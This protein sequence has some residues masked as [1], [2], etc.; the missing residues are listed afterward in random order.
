M[1]FVLGRDGTDGPAA[2]LGV[3]RAIDGSDGAP[4]AL[5]LERP[6][7][8]TVVGK[9]GYGKSH[10]LGVLAEELAATPGLAPVVVDPMG[11]FEPL[12]VQDAVDATVTT[13]PTVDPAALD[14][15]SWCPLVGLDPESGPGGLVWDA[16]RAADS[17]AE[18][19]DHVGLA[20]APAADVRAA[21]NHLAMAEAWGVFDPDGLG[22]ADLAGDEVTVLDCSGL[23]SGPMNAL[24]RVV[25]ETCYRARVDERID[26]LPW[27]LVDEAHAFFD[28]IAA[29]A[30]ETLLTRGRAPG[31]SL[32][33]ATQRPSAVPDVCLSQTDVLLAH[34]LTSEADIA[35][36]ESARPT[37]VDRSFAARMPTEVGGAVVVDD[38][39]ETAH[40]VRIRDRRT[41]HGGSSPRA[42]EAAPTD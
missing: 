21:R 42:S 39:T 40:A 28:G 11:A 1:T 32:V 5:D 8:V 33:V 12:G 25:A 19:R 20:D 9:R 24:A 29:E 30:L 26:R 16:A 3:Y 14:P 15:A 17:L 2:D 41:P 22:A 6:H 35:A 23:D 34:R 18:M 4:V 37:Y 7:A 38:A 13:D 10:T 31:V 27:L 36:L